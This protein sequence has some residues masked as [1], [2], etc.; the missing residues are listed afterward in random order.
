MACAKS[1][2]AEEQVKRIVG[3]QDTM[4]SATARTMRLRASTPPSV[5]I[6]RL[7]YHLQVPDSQYAYRDAARAEQV[8]VYALAADST[9]E[10]DALPRLPPD[11]QAGLTQAV[12]GVRALWRLAG[13]TDLS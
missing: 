4:V 11:R 2:S 8:G 3:A 7:R 6:D 9:L 13:I 10:Q 12:D 1:G 5:P